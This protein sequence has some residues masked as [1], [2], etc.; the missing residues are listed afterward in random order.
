[1]QIVFGL[2]LDGLKPEPSQ[3]VAGV[4]IL[5]SR[6]FLEVLES[7]LGLPTPTSHPSEAAFNYLQCPARGFNAG[8]ILPPLA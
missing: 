7:Q 8:Q 6:G 1:M 4:V 3:T 5:G 2:H